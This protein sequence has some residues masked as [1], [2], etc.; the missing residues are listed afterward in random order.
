MD[1]VLAAFGS[2]FEATGRMC[3]G[4]TLGLQTASEAVIRVVATMM[5][6]V[7]IS[8][9][10]LARGVERLYI[11]FLYILAD[12]T[13]EIHPPKDAN[14]VE[15]ALLPADEAELRRRILLDVARMGEMGHPLSPGFWRQLGRED[16]ALETEALLQNENAPARLLTRGTKQ[17]TRPAL[18]RERESFEVESIVSQ[19]GRYYLVRWAGYHPTWEPWRIQGDV[20]TAIETWEPWEKLKETEAMREWNEQ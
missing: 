5:A 2:H 8:H 17:V 3:A 11:N 7:E 19:K 12:E 1:E 10:P 6:G 20:G 16:K 4:L 14:R 15:M 9:V 18:K 13:G